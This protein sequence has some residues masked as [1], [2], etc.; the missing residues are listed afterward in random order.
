[1]SQHNRNPE[2][3]NIC[4]NLAAKSFYGGAEVWK[5]IILFLIQYL[6]ADTFYMRTPGGNCIFSE[7][8]YFCLQKV[9]IIRI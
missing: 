6:K 8:F 1:M 5:C 9:A 3:Q 7:I 2:K 4:L